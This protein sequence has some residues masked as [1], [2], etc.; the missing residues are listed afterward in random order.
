MKKKRF[1]TMLLTAAMVFG[2]VTGASAA[3]QITV[4]ID[5]EKVNFKDQQPVNI[6]DRV[7]VPVR[8]VAEKMGW[9][10]SFETFPGNTIVNGIFRPEDHVTMQKFVDPGDD[11]DAKF[12]YVTNIT[13]DTNKIV[14]GNDAVFEP[15]QSLKVKPIIKNGRTLL[16]IR[17]IAEGLYADIQ[18]NE[19]TKTVA[20]T[21]KPVEQFPNYDELMNYIEEYK[22]IV[23]EQADKEK[24]QREADEKTQKEQEM[25]DKKSNSQYA[26]EILRLVNEE[27][28]KAGIDPVKLD[29]TLTEAAN[30]RAKEICEV[31]DHTR[32][33]GENFRS[34]LD[35]MDV[36]SSYAGENIAGVMIK[37]ESVMTLW[38]NSE[39]HKA[40]IL[41][42]D[43]KYL[44][45]GYLYDESSEYQYYWVQIFSK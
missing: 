19:E 32:P 13:I 24:I 16:G 35:E 15:E 17:D 26:E 27:R 33:N 38:M 18:W 36:D 25:I 21:T 44:G 34:L 45:V 22:E 1:T 3:D 14:F 6:N 23:K 40:N 43:F 9:E 31:F 42:P 4:T 41:N 10:V 5:G 30:I 12:S 39:G 2:T 11:L 20:I 29:D 7:M 37:P 28:E 8:D